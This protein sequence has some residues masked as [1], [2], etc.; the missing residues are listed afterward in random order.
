L[1]AFKCN[2]FAKLE[3]C[4]RQTRENPDGLHEFYQEVEDAWHDE[5]TSL[6]LAR[7]ATDFESLLIGPG[8]GDAL[9]LLE[10]ELFEDDSVGVDMS[11]SP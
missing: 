7:W 2:F 9:D 4:D 1:E 5:H 3:A 10:Q 8:E 11:T 6:W